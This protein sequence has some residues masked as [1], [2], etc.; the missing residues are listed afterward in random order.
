LDIDIFVH[1]CGQF[2]R[3]SKQKREKRDEQ[4][5]R[6]FEREYVLRYLYLTHS[7]I[8]AFNPERR[9]IHDGTE[10]RESGKEPLKGWYVRYSDF[11]ISINSSDRPN[12]K[13]KI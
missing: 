6:N 5:E 1:S 12:R 9:E 13:G 3:S 4:W 11:H 8:G 7:L 2:F 10:K